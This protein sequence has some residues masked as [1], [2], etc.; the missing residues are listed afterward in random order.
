MVEKR[1][2]NFTESGTGPIVIGDVTVHARWRMSGVQQYA[3]GVGAAVDGRRTD[4][5][6]AIYFD[7]LPEEA[8]LVD[9]L[10]ARLTADPGSAVDLD[11]V[12]T[13][14][15]AMYYQET[16]TDQSGAPTGVVFAQTPH[17]S[18]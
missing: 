14:M 9:D 18:V 17:D 7:K 2:R 13:G 5:T 11:L 15:A 4:V 3:I 8:P 1:T 6:V 10:L 12:R 16:R